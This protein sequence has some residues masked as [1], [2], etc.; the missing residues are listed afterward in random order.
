MNDTQLDIFVS[1]YFHVS[2]MLAA[3]NQNKC[4]QNR[5][6]HLKRAYVVYVIC[7]RMAKAKAATQAARHQ[8]N[9][10]NR[11]LRKSFATHI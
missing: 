3:I 5:S 8:K 11:E 4:S 7:Y 6:N 9:D 1:V 2:E 10:V